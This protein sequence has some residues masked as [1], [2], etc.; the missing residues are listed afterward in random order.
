MG[1]VPD[2][3]LDNDV[4]IKLTAYD[5]LG[6]AQAR[7][8]AVGVLGAAKFV[9]RSALERHRGL[10]DREAAKARWE[11]SLDTIELL[12]PTDDEIRL[13]TRLEESAAA[14]GLP[15]DVGESQLCAMTITRGIAHL[16]TGDKRAIAAA[17]VMTAA[18]GELLALA[19]RV[20]CLE[21]LASHLVSDLGAEEV[22]RRVCA[23]PGVDRSLSICLSCAGLESGSAFDPAGLVSYAESLRAAA[24]TLLW[25]D[26]S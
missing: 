8:G 21:Q 6:A 12:E 10:Q 25:K 23:E 2:A 14:S 20:L 4:L 13:A 22:R 24:P 16:V 9:V 5:L 26:D 11:A 19:G 7:L 18:V 17:E 3:A 1:E 15:L